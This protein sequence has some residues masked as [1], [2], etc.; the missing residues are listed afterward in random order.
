MINLDSH[1]ISHHTFQEVPVVMATTAY[2][3]KQFGVLSVA[4]FSAVIGLLWGLIM[5]LCLLLGFGGA[6]S[7]MGP[8]ALG[9]GVGIVGLVMMI[10]LGGIFGFISGAIIAYVYN[11]VLGAIGGIEMDLEQKA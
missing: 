1:T 3:I 8:Q 7:A 2:M 5:G 6:A 11:I 10:I 4:K 9:I